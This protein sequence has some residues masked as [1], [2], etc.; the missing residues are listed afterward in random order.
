VS[1]VKITYS[2]PTMTAAATSDVTT[3]YS[4]TMRPTLLATLTGGQRITES[5][6]SD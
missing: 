1:G 4:L 2:A 5:Y 6:A 3:M